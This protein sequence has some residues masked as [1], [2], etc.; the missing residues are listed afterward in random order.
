MF[1]FLSNL[2]IKVK[3]V[4][5][6]I[7]GIISFVC[8]LSL[9]YYINFDS[10]LKRLAMSDQEMRIRMFWHLMEDKGRNIDLVDNKLKIGAYV[11]Q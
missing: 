9:V 4:G 10:E 8:I 6:A 2:T 7:C 11:H 5:L 3:M 1:D